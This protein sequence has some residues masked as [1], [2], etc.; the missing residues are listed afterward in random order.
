[1]F[2]VAFATRLVFVWHSRQLPFFFSPIIDAQGYDS[3]AVELDHDGDLRSAVPQAPLYTMFLAANYFLFG[4]GYFAPRVVQ[5]YMGAANCV[6]VQRLGARLSGRT[7]GIIAGFAAAVYGPLVFY[8][9]DLLREVLVIFLA[10]ALLL[11]LL[12][13]RRADASVGP[14]RAGS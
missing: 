7:A 2:A 1:M 3:R 6:M 14:R 11:C 9:T 5:C 8:E 13:W 12:R 10:L 4:H